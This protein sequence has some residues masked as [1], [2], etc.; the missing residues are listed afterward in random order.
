VFPRAKV[1]R[2]KRKLV[3]KIRIQ[4]NCEPWKELAAAR[5]EMTH[6]AKAARRKG[7]IVR[8]KW[9]R[10]K[11]ERGIQKVRKLHE[12]RKRVKDPGGGRSRY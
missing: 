10:A 3:R 12:G 9:T 11:A 5:R 1:A 4:E 6:R 7:S 2:R 8:N